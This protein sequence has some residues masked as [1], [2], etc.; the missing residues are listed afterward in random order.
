MQG[1]SSVKVWTKPLSGGRQAVLGVNMGARPSDLVL[2]MTSIA[3]RL[4]CAKGAS[5]CL[6]SDVWRNK[7]LG[8]AGVG[9]SYKVSGVAS[10]D[11]ETLIFA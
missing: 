10:H 4:A 5:R 6:V 2:D 8:K 3:P 11:S 7:T 1:T 9:G